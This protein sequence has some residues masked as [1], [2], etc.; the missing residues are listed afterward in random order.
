[1]PEPPSINAG[2]DI[3]NDI[4]LHFQVP[5]DLDAKVTELQIG[6]SNF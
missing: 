5:E 4:R 6:F 1:M 3:H 2:D